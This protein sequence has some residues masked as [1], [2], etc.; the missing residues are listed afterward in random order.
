[1]TLLQKYLMALV[2][3]GA[4]AMVFSNPTGVYKAA[5]SFRT[6]TSAPIVDVTTGGKGRVQV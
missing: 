6:V 5:Q 2:G 1:M 4:G 3:L